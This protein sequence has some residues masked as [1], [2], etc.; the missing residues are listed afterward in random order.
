MTEQDFFCCC[1]WFDDDDDDGHY[2]L[3]D[4]WIRERSGV[5]RNQSKDCSMVHGFANE[6]C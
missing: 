5:S 2:Y 1:C 3:S 4:F 6:L